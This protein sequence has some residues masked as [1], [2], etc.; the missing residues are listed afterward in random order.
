MSRR[1]RVRLLAKLGGS[2]TATVF[3]L[4]GSLSFTGTAKGG[5]L[6]RPVADSSHHNVDL[7]LDPFDFTQRHFRVGALSRKLENAKEFD[8][9]RAK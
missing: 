8:V 9:S 3:Y 5:C 4:K 7:N 1:H 6:F 2:G